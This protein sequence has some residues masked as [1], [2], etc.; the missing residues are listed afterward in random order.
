MRSIVF[1]AFFLATTLHLPGW[2]DHLPSR[3][4]EYCSASK[5][6]FASCSSSNRAFKS[7]VI[8]IHGWG[9]H[10]DET[11]GN[12]NTTLFTHLL[13]NGVSDVDCF[14]Y[15]T[16]G[17][18]IETSVSQ[19]RQRLTKLQADGYSEFEFVTHSMGGIVFLRM[20]M[21]DLLSDDKIICLVES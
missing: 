21:D 5:N 15:S 19:L 4:I 9:G 11:F 7:V 20:L 16:A 8:A 17:Q 6:T 2:A 13:T 14:E 18:S 1:V 12:G 3:E 10:C